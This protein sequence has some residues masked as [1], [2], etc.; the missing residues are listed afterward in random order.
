MAQRRDPAAQ[1][2][3]PPPTPEEELLDVAYRIY[4][5]VRGIKMVVYV[6]GGLTLGALFIAFLTAVVNNS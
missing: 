2:H 3:R 4:E 6:W 5:D 1:R